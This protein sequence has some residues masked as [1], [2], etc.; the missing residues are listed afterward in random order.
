[1]KSRSV[2]VIFVAFIA[3]FVLAGPVTA[4][5]IVVSAA[6]PA[7][8]AQGTTGLSV[9]ITGKGFKRGANARFLRTGTSDPDGIVVNS[10]TYVSSDE[11]IANI[12][13]SPQTSLDKFDIEVSAAGRTGKGTEMFG[14]IPGGQA[15]GCVLPSSSPQFQLVGTL[16]S[17]S[18]TSPRF[19]G[20]FGVHVAMRPATISVD[21]SPRA[22]LVA[23]VGSA[24][25]RAIEVFVL[26]AQSG[27]ELQHVSVVPD[28]SVVLGPRSMAAGDVNDD[29]IPDFA[30]A[31]PFANAAFVLVGDTT[32]GTLSYSARRVSTNR[33]I[34]C[35]RL[36]VGARRPERCRR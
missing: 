21:G 26:D 28:A 27:A 24:E 35:V 8:A 3:A 10:T 33:N 34:R 7:S 15:A 4:Q 12:D 17:L 20:S 11:L 36:G 14:V 31:D 2:I 1:M 32:D 16:N 5:D 25:S 22:A 29:G 13:V 9:R 6:D 18:G 23:A 30:L 19:T